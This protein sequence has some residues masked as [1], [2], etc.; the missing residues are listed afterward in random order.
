MGVRERWCW[1]RGNVNE[2]MDQSSVEE[3]IM[4]SYMIMSG[5][6]RDFKHTPVDVIDHIH[7]IITR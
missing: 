6:F 1:G 5:S 7:Q 4:C 3:L 2:C